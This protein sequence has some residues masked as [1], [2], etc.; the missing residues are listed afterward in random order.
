MIEAVLNSVMRMDVDEFYLF[1]SELYYH[2]MSGCFYDNP[3]SPE[4]R[5]KFIGLL[6]E[7]IESL[8]GEEDGNR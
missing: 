1:C 2:G 8:D 3:P 5:P 4:D 6:A 7:I